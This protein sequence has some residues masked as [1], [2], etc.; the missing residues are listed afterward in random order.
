[1]QLAFVDFPPLK[2]ILASVKC[3]FTAVVSACSRVGCRGSH[4]RVHASTGKRAYLCAIAGRAAA[5]TAGD[6]SR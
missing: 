5:A 4:K 6:R 1:M 3:R 2:R